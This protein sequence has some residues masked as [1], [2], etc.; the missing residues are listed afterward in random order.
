VIGTSKS[1]LDGGGTMQFNFTQPGGSYAVSTGVG[2]N[3]TTLTCPSLLGVD[4][5]ETLPGCASVILYKS[6][7][8]GGG[9]WFTSAWGPVVTNGLPQTVEKNIKLE[10]GPPSST[11]SVDGVATDNEAV[12]KDGLKSS[13]FR[14]MLK[15]G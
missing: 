8:I 14:A 11:S 4:G 6:N 13:D 9:V 2:N 1:G 15:G 3:T 10:V 12:C 7:G 5:A